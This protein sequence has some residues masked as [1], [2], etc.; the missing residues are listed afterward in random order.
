[1][2]AWILLVECHK[3]HFVCVSAA[4]V[5]PWCGLQCVLLCLHSPAL[6][7]YWIGYASLIEVPLCEH[8]CVW[9]TVCVCVGWKVFWSEIA[10]DF[11]SWP[12]AR[13]NEQECVEL[14]FVKIREC[15]WL[16]E[17][18]SSRSHTRLI[19]YILSDCSTLC[20]LAAMSC[21][22]WEDMWNVVSLP[23]RSFIYGF[24][25]LSPHVNSISLCTC[26]LPV[27]NVCLSVILLF[28]K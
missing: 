24:I 22:R 9:K 2:N 13:W 11:L 28:A 17:F 23:G 18:V 4:P 1:M 3:I 14:T 27:S 16:T 8:L 19:H 20:L 26:G 6:L 5:W 15:L 12:N 10:M 21:V 7:G 25:S